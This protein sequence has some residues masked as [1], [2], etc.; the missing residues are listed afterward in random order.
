MKDV[1]KG[2]E[3]A[4]LAFEQHPSGFSL[5]NIMMTT[6]YKFLAPQVID[7]IRKHFEQFLEDKESLRKESGYHDKLIAAFMICERLANFSKK[8]NDDAGADRYAKLGEELKGQRLNLIA[9]RNW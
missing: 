4:K 8:N 1:L 6:N 9:N 2:F 3:Y 7:Y 5:Q